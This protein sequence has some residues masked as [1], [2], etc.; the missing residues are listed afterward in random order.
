M[1]AGNETRYLPGAATLSE[2]G[3]SDLVMSMASDW[4]ELQ[5]QTPPEYGEVHGQ[6]VVLSRASV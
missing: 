3:V 1:L 4:T 2:A 6:H 5:M